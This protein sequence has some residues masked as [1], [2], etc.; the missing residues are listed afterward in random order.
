MWNLFY[1]ATVV[2]RY[3]PY[4]PT[5]TGVQPLITAMMGGSVVV[6]MTVG[7]TPMNVVLDTGASITLSVSSTSLDRIQRCSIDNPPRRIYGSVCDYA[8]DSDIS[9]TTRFGSCYYVFFYRVP[10]V[11]VAAFSPVVSRPLRHVNVGS[12]DLP[13]RRVRTGCVDRELAR[14]KRDSRNLL[15]P[16]AGKHYSY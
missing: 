11:T 1:T 15:C 7:G 3:T 4:D 13:I 16:L 14:V 9:G 5:T 12:E 6:S 10:R 2:V 8:D